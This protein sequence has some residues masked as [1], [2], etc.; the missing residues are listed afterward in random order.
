M[1]AHT[2][3]ERILL[4]LYNMRA[5]DRLQCLSRSDLL[6]ALAMPWLAVERDVVQLRQLKLIETHERQIGNTTFH[7]LYLTDTGVQFVDA[8]QAGRPGSIGLGSPTNAPASAEG[9]ALQELLNIH[10]RRLALLKKKAAM[11]G[12]SRD[13]SVDMEIADIEQQMKE[14]HERMA[15]RDM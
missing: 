11:L 3:R 9:L 14:I 4:A 1:D 8:L 12:I 13:P 7:T 2:V 10:V 5:I 15:S 6:R